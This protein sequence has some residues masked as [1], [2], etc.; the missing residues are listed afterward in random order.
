EDWEAH[1][2]GIAQSLAPAGALES[3]L[4]GRVALCLWRLRRVAAYETGVTAVGLEEAAEEARR[5]TPAPFETPGGEEPVAAQLQK[6]RE[7]LEER[8]E[9]ADLG[10]GALDLLR[11]LPDL[12]DEAPV[13]PDDAYGALQDASGELP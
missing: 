9:T 2:A 3:E 11:R 4:A 5:V 13:N 1:R 6:A 12:P 7:S 10:E 8:R